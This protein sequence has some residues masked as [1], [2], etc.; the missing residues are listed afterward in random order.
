M[1]PDEAR[2]LAHR[3]GPRLQT[4]TRRY[5]EQAQGLALSQR[6]VGRLAQDENPNAPAM[7][8]EDGPAQVREQ[9]EAGNVITGDG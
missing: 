5:R 6:P 4:R 3:G 9:F 7:K 1:K 8:R 2:R